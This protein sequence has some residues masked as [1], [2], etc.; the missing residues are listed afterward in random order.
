M[1]NDD[2]DVAGLI[3][4]KQEKHLGEFFI[5]MYQKFPNEF[6]P[7]GV[8]QDQALKSVE[9]LY[10]EY[11]EMTPYLRN[12]RFAFARGFRSATSIGGGG[13]NAL[14]IRKM[15]V[16]QEGFISEGQ[17]KKGGGLFGLGGGGDDKKKQDEQKTGGNMFK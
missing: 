1:G 8:V 13:L 14:L 9:D 12:M 4:E 5:D 6:G 15:M 2:S 10:G 11:S 17:E 16:R 7:M 3:L